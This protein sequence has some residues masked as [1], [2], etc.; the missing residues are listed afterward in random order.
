[1]FDLK[2]VRKR[3]QWVTTFPNPRTC[4]RQGTDQEPS[5]FCQGRQHLMN[6]SCWACRPPAPLTKDVCRAKDHVRSHVV[7]GQLAPESS[8]PLLETLP[9]NPQTS[10]PQRGHCEIC[11]QSVSGIWQEANSRRSGG[12]VSSLLGRVSSMARAEGGS[13]RLH[14]QPGSRMQGHDQRGTLHATP[15]SHR[16]SRVRRCR[17]SQEPTCRVCAAWHFAGAIIETVARA[18]NSKQQANIGGRVR[19]Q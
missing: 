2:Q 18:N 19:S 13:A 12:E 4:L 17:R 9:H 1:M 16:G 6:A 5:D 8:S 14:V 3:G 11:L 10:L 7:L 15:F